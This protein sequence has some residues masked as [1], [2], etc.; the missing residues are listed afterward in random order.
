MPVSLHQPQETLAERNLMQPLTAADAGQ[1]LAQV[2][3]GLR[4]LHEN[5]IIHGCV[6]P[7]SI[8]IEHSSP[9]SIKLTDIG[10][11]PYVEFEDQE[12]RA[13]YASQ[14]DGSTS[15][16]V[17]VWD[18]WSAGVIGLELLSSDGLPP[19]PTK[20]N[21]TQRGWVIRVANRAIAFRNAE[22]PSPEGNKEAALFLTRV[23]EVELLDRLTAEKCLQDTWL[24]HW[25]MPASDDEEVLEEVTV[26]EKGSDE[27]T[28]TEDPRSSI[29]KGKQ[30]LRAR[31]SSV[32]SPG[33]QPRRPSITP[34]SPISK[35]KQPLHAR[36]PS[37]TSPG[38]Q[39]RRP[40]KTPQ[41]SPLI[42]SR[43]NTV[44]PSVGNEYNDVS[45]FEGSGS[46]K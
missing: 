1:V 27:V 14:K 28:E 42:G 16:P 13:L 10:L 2:F 31:R 9:W 44:E 29:S 15:K 18:T 5:G 4:Y 17:P 30:P 7:G 26:E 43:H 25:R 12:E 36:R 23:L 21:Y 35:G 22:K 24:K 39:P 45:G 6:C 40:S 20:P 11:Y 37:I 46:Q 34:R 41:D 38:R 8:L 32:T 3:E 19:R 33:H